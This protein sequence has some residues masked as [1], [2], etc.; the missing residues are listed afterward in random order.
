MA[1]PS[2]IELASQDASS[3]PDGAAI[4]CRNNA[5]LLQLAFRLLKQGKAVRMVGFDIGAGLIRILRKLGPLD[6][7]ERAAFAA[8]DQWRDNALLNAKKP[9]TVYD[10]AECLHAL[11]EGKKSLG[12]AIILADA[13]FKSTAGVNLL[14]GHKAKGLEWDVVFHLDPWRVPSRWVSPG[15]EAY[16]QELN[17]RYVIETRFKQTLYVVTM[18]GYGNGE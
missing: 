1:A 6:M 4:L 7:S 5:P 14:S 8:I 17:V 9:E 10:R 11:V 18:E 2:G 3:I 12:D 13:L 16:E 15:T